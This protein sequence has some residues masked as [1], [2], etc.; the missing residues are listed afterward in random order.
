MPFEATGRLLGFENLDPKPDDETA[1]AST[2]G[3]EPLVIATTAPDGETA[4]P[5]PEVTGKDEG[6]EYFEPNPVPGVKAHIE[7][8][9]D[10]EWPRTTAFV[11]AAHQELLELPSLFVG[12]QVSEQEGWSSPLGLSPVAQD[13]ALLMSYTVHAP[14]RG[15]G[16]PG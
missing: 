11:M 6:F 2:N 16:P 14:L 9:G 5:L 7:M 12:L 8:Y 4:T 15:Y 1:Y 13:S 10:V 3:E